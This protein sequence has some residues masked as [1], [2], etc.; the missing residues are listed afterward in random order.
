MVAQLICNQSAAG[1]SP[2]LSSIT[3]VQGPAIGC[4]SSTEGDPV[5]A[6]EPHLLMRNEP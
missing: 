2:A 6:T 3:R 1:S 5:P 4:L